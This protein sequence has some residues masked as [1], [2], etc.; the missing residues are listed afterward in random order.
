MREWFD[1]RPALA[2]LRLSGVIGARGR[3]GLTLTALRPAIDKAFKAGDRV[4]LVVNSPGGAPAQ[5]QLIHDHIRLKAREHK[6]PVVTFVEDLAASGGYWIAL[7]GDRVFALPTSL[8]GSIGV[9]SAGF[10]FVEAL[11]KL[12]LERRVH[13][14]G[15]NKV[16][17]DPFAPE[18]SEDAAWLETLQGR[19]HDQFIAHVR[20]RRAEQGAPLP[21][22]AESDLFSGDLWLAE[23]ARDHGLICGLDSL[24]AYAAREGM[25]LKEIAQPRRLSLRLLGA[26][27]RVEEGL[28][29]LEALAA[30][31]LLRAR[32]GL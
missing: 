28:A 20:S 11:G 26:E 19:L 23:E 21:D 18:K 16:R 10:G 6:T 31:R 1:R 3:G 5:A 32:C 27:D 13:A 22:A 8:V 24:S 25:R 29:A 17:L 9:V 15:A 12:G 14:A 30:D 2:V 4:A 7:A